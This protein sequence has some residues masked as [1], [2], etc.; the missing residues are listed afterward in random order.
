MKHLG[1]IQLET[2]RLV[3]RRFTI[4]DARFCVIYR[5][6]LFSLLYRNIWEVIVYIWIEDFAI[7]KYNS[8]YHVTGV[9]VVTCA[10]KSN[11]RIKL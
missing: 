4:D 5:G 11:L 2:D 3:L 6:N 8:K 9:D 10:I 7:N 1:T